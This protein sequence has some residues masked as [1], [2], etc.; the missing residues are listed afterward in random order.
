MQRQNFVSLPTPEFLNLGQGRWY[1]DGYDGR[2]Y[3]VY[4]PFNY[5]VGT[6]V[7]LIMMLHGC[8]EFPLGFAYLSHMNL[9]ADRHQFLVVYPRAIDPKHLDLGACWN[10]FLAV[11]QQRGSGE[12]ASLAGI[13]ESMLQNTSRWTIDPQRIYV[14]GVSAG[15]C[16]AVNMGVT[17]PDLFAAIGVHSGGEYQAY[18]LSFRL[19]QPVAA[20]QEEPA[21]AAVATLRDEQVLLQEGLHSVIPPGPDPII[22]GQKA[23]EAMGAFA[24]VVPT[25]V[26]HG[27]D[28]HVVDPINGEQVA[29]QWHRTN[30]LAS[31]G[32]FT[33]SFEHPSSVTLAQVPGGRHYSVFTWQDVH[34]SDVV[35]Y[36]KVDEMGHAW[37]GGSRGSIYADPAGPDASQA[38]YEFFMAHPR[39]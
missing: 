14:A 24:R 8:A 33:A 26:F 7:P 37:S 16:V 23:Y 10:W 28:D 30:Q 31:H 17:Y 34:G 21:Q 4:I 25:I 2:R 19:R 11:N 39:A 12:P 20:G 1:H 5:Q 38:M 32:A 22:Q 27:T 15:A 13:V 29:H 6:A 9:L 35:T 3:Q 36:W 18:S